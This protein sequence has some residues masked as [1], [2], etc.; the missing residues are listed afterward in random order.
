MTRSSIFTQT[1]KTKETLRMVWK[2]IR[3]CQGSTSWWGEDGNP[4]HLWWLELNTMS[5]LQEK[6]HI[7]R[8][9]IRN[10]WTCKV[11]SI[12]SMSTIWRGDLNEDCEN[13]DHQSCCDKDVCS[14][15]HL[16][17]G[18]I[19]NIGECDWIMPPRP[20]YCYPFLHVDHLDEGKSDASSQPPVGHD[21]LLLQVDLLQTEPGNLLNVGMD[22]SSAHLLARKVKI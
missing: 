18:R 7:E 6:P 8:E 12:S 17:G 13:D 19:M 14:L 9:K 15:H 22:T 16:T 3:H 21:E 11:Q 4:G 1:V 2:S 20:E 5:F 10:S